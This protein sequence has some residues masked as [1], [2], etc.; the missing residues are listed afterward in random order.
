M[1]AFAAALFLALLSIPAVADEGASPVAAAKPAS[2]AAAATLAHMASPEQARRQNL[3]SV[4]FRDSPIQEVFQMLAQGERVNILLRKGITGN[5]SISLYD[6]TVPEA[7][8]SIAEAGGY[9]VEEPRPR[10]YLVMERKDAALESTRGETSVRSY[11]VQYSNPKSVADI[12]AKHLSRYGKITPL[13]ERGLLVIEDLPDFHK[14]IEKLLREI[15]LEP[16]Q[17]M[18][19]AKILEIALDSGES[20]GIDWNQVVGSGSS[21]LLGTQGLASR[22]TPGFFFSIVNKN[23]NVYLSALS[24]KGRVHTLST[25]KLLALENQEATVKIGDSLGYKVTTTINLITT[26]SVQYLETGVILKV[27]PSVDQRGLILMKIHP[28]VSSGSLAEGIP[29]KKS[30]E[31]TTQLLA[32]DGQSILIGGLIK[33]SATLR[34]KGVPGLGDVPIVGWL[35][36]NKEESVQSSETVVLITPHV[37]RRAGVEAA[38]AAAGPMPAPEMVLRMEQLLFRKQTRE[39][40]Q[41]TGAPVVERSFVADRPPAAPD[42]PVD[43]GYAY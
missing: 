35:F 24:A 13:L 25:P 8:Q 41:Q 1:R 43:N 19:E 39:L 7:I 3:I 38:S 14:R 31:V 16:L 23:L 29:S 36:S 40:E 15:D 37:M 33:N 4:S 42:A 18:I 9:A 5:V 27:V 6:V 32:E 20:F 10:E 21:G 22:G 30:T 12:L 11:K 2:A 34:R 28:E 17:I 26:E